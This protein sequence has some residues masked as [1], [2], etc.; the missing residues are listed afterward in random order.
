MRVLYD[1]KYM[2]QRDISGQYLLLI[3][4]AARDCPFM[5]S[6]FQ[7]RVKMIKLAKKQKR[8]TGGRLGQL[9]PKGGIVC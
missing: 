8:G 7:K 3:K 1:V 4:T 5:T 9:Q 2:S 6:L